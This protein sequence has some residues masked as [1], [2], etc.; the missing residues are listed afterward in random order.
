[1]QSHCVRCPCQ[2]RAATTEASFMFAVQCVVERG[3]ENGFLTVQAPGSLHRMSHPDLENW[4]Q[5]RC[6]RWQRCSYLLYNS[7]LTV[8]L[9]KRSNMYHLKSAKS[10]ALV[11]F[12]NM[13]VLSF[14]TNGLICVC[15]YMYMNVHTPVYMQ[16]PE[17]G[18]RCPVLRLFP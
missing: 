13:N 2:I 7:H 15:V 14:R 1:M 3:E 11:C 17:N 18:A 5:S 6:L 16:R 8:L 4:S 9:P 10:K 12:Q